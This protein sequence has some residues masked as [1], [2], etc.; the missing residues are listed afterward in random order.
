MKDNDRLQFGDDQDLQIYHNGPSN[1]IVAAHQTHFDVNNYLKQFGD[2]SAKNF[3]TWSANTDLVKELK[4][5][6]TNLKK[7]SLKKHLNESV[8]K[9]AEKM[10]HTPSICKK[11]YI[12]KENVTGIEELKID[13]TNR[14]STIKVV[15]PP[16][17]EA[18]VK[19]ETVQELVDKLKN[20][21]KI[22]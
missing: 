15:D 20:E 12:N 11:N 2:F 21:V 14:L 1:H 19:V 3:R 10:H 17:R 5:S 7:N 16:T 13:V 8:K 6:T 18:G 9:V 4:K 22:I